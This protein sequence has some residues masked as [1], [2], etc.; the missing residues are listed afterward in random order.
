M[1]VDT[2]THVWPDAIALRALAA[3][4]AL[5]R[6][7]DGTLGSLEAALSEAGVDRAVCLGVAP[8]GAR[9]EAANAFLG[10]LDG[11]RYIGFG[12]IHPDLTPDENLASLRKNGLRGAKVHPIFQSYSL[13]DPRLL[14]TLD[15]M[16]G[17][18]AVVVH[19]G[20]GGRAEDTVRCTPAM[21]RAL[22]QQLP[23]LDLIACHFGGFSMLDAAS[24]EVVG[25]PVHLDT[26]WPPTVAELEPKRIAELIRRHGADRVLFA[27]D[28]PMASIAREL[29]AL[30]SLPLEDDEIDALIGGNAERLLGL[31]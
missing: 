22:V 8:D 11:A 3:V 10:D 9:V 13:D 25:L 27:S 15:A 24:A 18:F 6:I 28:W 23:G 7:G 26:A 31:L 14:A 17:E 5:E 12:S 30:R 2:H 29:D 21:M 20:A 1:I 19:V 16:R 4:P